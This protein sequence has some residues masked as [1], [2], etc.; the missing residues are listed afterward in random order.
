MTGVQTCALPISDVICP[1]AIKQH[2]DVAYER[3]RETQHRSTQTPKIVEIK[4]KYDG[5]DLKNVAEYHQLSCEEVIQ[6][7]S[8]A[9]YHTYF[10]GFSA[11]FPYLA[12]VN[13][14][15]A[16]P[17]RSEPRIRVTAGSVGIAESQTGIYTV[18]SPG[19]WQIIGHTVDVVFDA[20]RNVPC[21]IEP[22]DL[23]KF[24]SV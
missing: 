19:G 13:P 18:D 4:V 1:E 3:A 21:M 12:G 7:H 16:T 11:G 24:I 17:R 23:V 15:I 6:R 10:L 14:S 5:E 9:V 20:N 8:E 2:L 22:G